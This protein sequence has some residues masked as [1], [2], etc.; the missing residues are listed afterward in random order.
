MNGPQLG[1]NFSGSDAGNW[2]KADSGKSVQAFPDSSTSAMNGFSTWT[3]PTGPQTVIVTDIQVQPQTSGFSL[4]GQTCVGAEP[5][6]GSD[7][8]EVDVSFDPWDN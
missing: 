5:S 4:R 2:V 1:Y 3:L 7:Q 6:D 8:C